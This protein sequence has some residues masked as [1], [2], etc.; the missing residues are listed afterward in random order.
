MTFT[1]PAGGT[2]G[3]VTVEGKVF[4]GKVLETLPADTATLAA[5]RDDL[6]LAL[7]KRKANERKE[8]FED[9][10]VTRLVKEGKVKKYPEAIQRLGSSYRS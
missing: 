9:G 5:Q 1:K 7:K 4:F 10:V 2:F 6:L 8:L 3:P